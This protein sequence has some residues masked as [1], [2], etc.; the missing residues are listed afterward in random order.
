VEVGVL[1][2]CVDK[3]CK[4]FGQAISMEKSGFFVSKGVHGQFSL[5]I[6]NQCGFKKLAKDVKYLGLPLFLSSNKS[7]DFSF[8]KEKLEARV[9]GWKCKSL[10]WMGRATLI[11]SVAQATPIYGMSAFKFP[12]G[13]CEEMNAIVRKFWWNPRIKGNKFFTPKA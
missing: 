3:Y 5:Q 2:G 6:C 10:S 8:V 9:S 7:K 1:M 12:K 13:L 4:W 11:K